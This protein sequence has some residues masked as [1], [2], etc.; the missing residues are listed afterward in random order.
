ME[1][2]KSSGTLITDYIQIGGIQASV[3]NASLMA[4]IFNIILAK[5][6]ID[7]TGITYAALSLIFGFSFFG[8]NILNIWPIVLGVYLYSQYQREHFKKYIYVAMFG[9]AMAPIISEIIISSPLHIGFRLGLGIATGV[10]MGFVLPNASSYM[11][12]VHHGY[13]LY[14]V[15]FSSGIIGT[16]VV[17][18][19]K[20]YGL[21]INTSFTWSTTK[22]LPLSFALYIV[23]LVLFIT[24]YY[25]ND[26]Q[27]KGLFN[28]YKYSGRLVSDFVVSEGQ[29]IA[30]MNMA[31]NGMLATTLVLILGGDI[32][33]PTIAGIFTI[34]GFGAFG[35]HFGNILPIW[36][37]VI[38]SIGI[39][40]LTFSDPGVQLTFLFSTGLAPIAGKFGIV[41]GVIA[42]MIHASLVMYVGVLHGGINLYNN[43]FSAGLVAAF[44]V[45]LIDSMRRGR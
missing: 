27:L 29:G 34:I 22:T 19:Y 39:R 38:L 9:T 5:N 45:P 30:L 32:N 4:M 18:L 37:G 16:I 8:K 15:G 14:N 40:G 23:L 13:N 31:I 44:I 12:K 3:I 42:G 43:G 1:I 7:Y 17:S 20:S 28:V 35:K 11:V 24:G 36:G 10:L 2:I 33:G 25:Y 21:N 41:F 6:N 26:R